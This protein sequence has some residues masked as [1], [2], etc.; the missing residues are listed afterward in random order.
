MQDRVQQ[1]A[2]QWTGGEGSIRTSTERLLIQDE[3]ERESSSEIRSYFQSEE[4]K[5]I[6]V[7]SLTFDEIKTKNVTNT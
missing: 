5:F 7:D 4:N 1:R 3:Q 2:P 6:V